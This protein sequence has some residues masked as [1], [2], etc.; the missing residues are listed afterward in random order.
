MKS[1]AVTTLLIVIVYQ[2]EMKPIRKTIKRC[3]PGNNEPVCPDYD[4]LLEAI[5]NSVNNR[6]RLAEKEGDMFFFLKR[7]AMRNKP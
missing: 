3:L 7:K 4:P 1:L 6:L 5:Q 2:A